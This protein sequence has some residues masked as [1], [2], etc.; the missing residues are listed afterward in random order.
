MVR[1]AA[2]DLC[3]GGGHRAAAAQFGELKGL[4]G[5]DVLVL[6]DNVAR[7]R[8]QR[9]KAASAEDSAARRARE[10]EA[11]RQREQLA[12]ERAPTAPPLPGVVTNAVFPLTLLTLPDGPRTMVALS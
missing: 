6:C 5:A 12:H 10:G 7:P 9:G 3:D 1:L 2:A 4:T 8:G 11:R